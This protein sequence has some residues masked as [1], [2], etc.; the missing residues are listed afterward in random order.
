MS[1]DEKD[2]KCE[3]DKEMVT[4][5]EHCEMIYNDLVKTA[6]LPFFQ[7]PQNKTAIMNQLKEQMEYI[8]ARRYGKKR[9]G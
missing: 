1:S 9:I 4:R 5:N 3:T 2:I 7:D 8:Y 6:N